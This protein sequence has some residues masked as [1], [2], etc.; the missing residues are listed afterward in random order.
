MRADFQP[1]AGDP[2]IQ[3]RLADFDP[4]GNPTTGITRTSTTTNTFF[5]IQSGGLA[6]DVKSTAN[7]GI[8]PWDQSKYLNIWVC[9]MEIPIFGSSILGYATPPDGLP[10]WPSGS[11]NGMSDGVVVQYQVFGRNNPNTIDL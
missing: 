8:D 1:H 9:N 2:M 7:G 11:T 5:N 4:Q 10:H 6:E 3:F